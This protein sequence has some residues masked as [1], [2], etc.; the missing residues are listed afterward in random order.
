MSAANV[1]EKRWRVRRISV[2]L[3]LTLLMAG[4]GL[5]GSVNA[6]GAVTEGSATSA[7]AC[8][9]G[10]GSVSSGGDQSRQE[11]TATV[12]P[13]V[14]PIWT[15]KN[16]FAVPP[17]VT[18]RF[19]YEVTISGGYADGWSIVGDSMFWTQYNTDE[20][21]Q[22]DGPPI[23]RLLGGGWG[24]FVAFEES[25][26]LD[27]SFARTTEYGLRKDG[28]LVRWT[29]DAKG[30]WHPA[31]MAKGFSAVKSMALISNPRGY[32][33]FLANT[34]GG[35]LYT[36]HIPTSSALK[37]VVK[38]VRRST[39]QAFESLTAQAC[40]KGVLLVGIDKDTKA[41]YLYAVGHANGTATPIQGRGR[42]PGSFDRQTYFRWGF[43]HDLDPFNGE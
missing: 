8:W 15:T 5:P 40:G 19:R 37:P 1:A 28:V 32:D 42:L 43:S 36:I 13:T 38:L 31:G 10:L 20:T 4:L 26:H 29:V 33:T 12:P 24:S 35:G 27:N 11:V 25:W 41:A 23:L 18:S 6:A 7:A 34:R 22:L 30:A 16:V 9:Q 39:W 3:G 17:R 14:Q 21:S 2:G